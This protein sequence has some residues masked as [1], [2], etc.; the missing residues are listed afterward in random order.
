MSL[1]R[2][3]LPRNWEISSPATIS[4]L[5]EEWVVQI[6]ARMNTWNEDA[7]PHWTKV[8]RGPRYFVKLEI[9]MMNGWR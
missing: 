7:N 8:L 2:L 3:E 1:P 9:D 5:F 4:Q 6:A